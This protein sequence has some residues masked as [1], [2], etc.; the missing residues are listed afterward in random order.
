MSLFKGDVSDLF[1]KYFVH[2][3]I[4][5]GYFASNRLKQQQHTKHLIKYHQK[6]NKILIVDF[7][8]LL[9]TFLYLDIEST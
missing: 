8:C 2:I 1:I 7:H 4:E 9:I 5:D 3:S 6:A